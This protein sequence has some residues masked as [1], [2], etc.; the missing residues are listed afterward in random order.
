MADEHASG[1][2][3]IE[4]GRCAPT[5]LSQSHDSLLTIF[6]ASPEQLSML[7]NSP[8]DPSLALSNA[9]VSA[10][11]NI[12][13]SPSMR[14]PSA[15]E[16]LADVDNIRAEDF[17]TPRLTYASN[18]AISSL[19]FQADTSNRDSD[20]IAKF[21]TSKNAVDKKKS[22][23]QHFEIT[24]LTS[25][26]EQVASSPSFR[27]T[28]TPNRNSNI[29]DEFAATEADRRRDSLV[30]QK[31]QRAAD[32]FDEVVPV[33]KTQNTMKPAIGISSEGVTR[34]KP[35]AV[36]NA[37]NDSEAQTHLSTYRQV[38]EEDLQ[39][40]KW[41]HSCTM[42][43]LLDFIVAGSHGLA[44]QYEIK[45]I[46]DAGAS[47]ATKATRPPRK[48]VRHMF[49]ICNVNEN[50]WVGFYMNLALKISMA[51]DPM[52]GSLTADQTL[53]LARNFVASRCG[54]DEWVLHNWKLQVCTVSCSLGSHSCIALTSFSNCSVI[55]RD[56]RK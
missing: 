53:L 32:T 20:V 56:L 36:D 3:S 50:H 52:E 39:P 34:S 44:E 15:A 45:V 40:G 2:L 35:I 24:S 23:T 14:N 13:A 30:P 48:E 29:I 46:G 11:T 5:P 43:A 31:R 18:Q 27:F 19:S 47:L 17:Q 12:L 28:Y 51:Y 1:D 55:S 41:L 25:T 54:E 8:N 21:A 7:E 22:S 42:H 4:Q 33:K 38:I 9:V 49:L 6:A 16:T 26:P 37:G 10:N